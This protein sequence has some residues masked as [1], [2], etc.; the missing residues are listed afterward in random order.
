[1]R[2]AALLLLPLLAL[3]TISQKRQ[4]K[5]SPKDFP[6]VIKKANESFGAAQYA[7]CI[8][9]LKKA[10]SMASGELRKQVFAAMPTPPE[11]WT[12]DKPKQDDGAA[13][14]AQ[15]G[16]GGMITIDRRYRGPDG[17]SLKVQV[18]PSSAL[19]KMIGMGFAMAANDPNSEIV[20]Y[21]GNKAI[22]KKSSKGKRFELNI[23]IAGKHLVQVNGSAMDEDAFFNMFNQAFVT[24][25][26]T[27]LGK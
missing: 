24:K 27:I 18:M 9:H 21:E 13:Y 25:I 3:P 7:E 19:A 16:L 10:I 2:A 8:A 6:A 5:A 14:L 23:L 22:F 11:G 17:K 1:M 26:A 4:K 15:M 20:D 12:A